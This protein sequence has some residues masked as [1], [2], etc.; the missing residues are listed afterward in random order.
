MIRIVNVDHIA[1][2]TCTSALAFLPL[3]SQANWLQKLHVGVVYEVHMVCELHLVEK[4]FL[5]R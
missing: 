4:L 2:C 5:R 3:Q 1:C